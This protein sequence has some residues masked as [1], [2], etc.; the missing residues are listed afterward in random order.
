MFKFKFNYLNLLTGKM[1]NNMYNTIYIVSLKF[2]TLFVTEANIDQAR[3]AEALCAA[4][5]IGVHMQ[6]ER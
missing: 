2:N 6:K 5:K 3:L 1:H 4:N